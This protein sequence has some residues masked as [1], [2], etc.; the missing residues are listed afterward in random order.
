MRPL[1][2]LSFIVVF[3]CNLVGE[4]SGTSGS[5][6]TPTGDTTT[7]SAP[8]SEPDGSAAIKKHMEA[9][10]AAVGSG[11]AEKVEPLLLGMAMT[12][13]DAKTWFSSHFGAELGAKLASEWESEIFANLPKLIR[14]FKEAH[15]EGKTEVKVTRHVNAGDASATGLQKAALEKMVKP[16]ALYTVHL[17]KPG[18]SSG[19]SLWSFAIEGGQLRLL[20]KMG[21]VKP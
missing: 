9:M 18:E 16:T 17:V 3:G 6:P 11:D 12:P 20:G 21:A 5:A 19:T 8:P 4:P 13:D 2:P 7:A 15:S 14:P 1:W 10:L